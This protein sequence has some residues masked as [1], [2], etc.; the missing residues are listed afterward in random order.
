M[1]ITVLKNAQTIE[2]SP[3]DVKQAVDIVIEG[4]LIRAVGKHAASGIQADKVIDCEGLYVHPGMVCSHHHYYS[5]L[6]RGIMATIPDSPDFISTLKNLWWRVDRALDEESVYYSSLICSLDAVRAGTT[7]VVDHHASPNFIKGS[8]HQIRRGFEAVGL[9]GMTCY[10][11]TD[12]NGGEKELREGVEENLRFAQEIEDSGPDRLME[13]AIGAHAPFTVPDAGMQMLSDAVAQT[14]RGLH[15]HLAEGAYDAS[16]SHHRYDRD[17]AF[18]LDDFD[19][20][21]D[22]SILVHGLYLNEAEIELINS[23]DA[24]LVHNARSN[25]NNNVGYIRH[26][27]K[28]KNLV[29][30]T[31]GIGAD[32][33]EEFKLAYFKHRDAGGQLWPDTFLS[34]LGRGNQL[35]SRYFDADFGRIEAG[36]K[37]DLVISDYKAPT[38]L[39][40]GNIAGHIAFSMGSNSVRT[41]LI[42]GSV[43]MEDRQFP[44]DVEEIYAA[45]AGQAKNLW[46]RV[47]QL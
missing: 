25:M 6:S 7:A 8:L 38:P 32:M 23:R 11:V 37:A 20:I 9:R 15:I 17:L 10:E 45:A 2:F 4:S 43:V 42:N 24:F 44:F 13:A 29:M 36:C 12:R 40:A 46:S 5:G 31:D 21:N 35:L 26:I 39:E 3:A 27:D 28:V 41:V 34:A 18:R 30:G 14:G 16:V 1:S 47:D 19:L 22:K 33:F